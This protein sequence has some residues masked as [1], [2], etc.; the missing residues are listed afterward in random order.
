MTDHRD[1]G[2]GFTHHERDGCVLS[3]GALSEPL[4]KQLGRDRAQVAQHQRDAD[5]IT[6]L[7]VRGILTETE[8]RKARMRL[9]KQM[10]L[11]HAG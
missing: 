3:F 6:R 1:R 7:L 8:G 5:S 2:P 10:G 4:H 9:L 11:R